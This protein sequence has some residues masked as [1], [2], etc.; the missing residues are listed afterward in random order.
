VGWGWAKCGF[1]KLDKPAG[2]GIAYGRDHSSDVSWM[3]AA[4]LQ[5]TNECRRSMT[6]LDGLFCRGRF[7]D[8]SGKHC[9]F[10][11]VELENIPAMQDAING[12]TVIGDCQVLDSLFLHQ[13][14]G[15]VD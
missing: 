2:R 3:S 13:E 7:R 1:R 4:V 11:A 14:Q 15:F 9:G 10:T 5:R 8:F 6:P 12:S